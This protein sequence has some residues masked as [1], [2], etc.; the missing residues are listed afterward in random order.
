M[1]NL[2]MWAVALI[3]ALQVEFRHW[4]VGPD[5]T[6]ERVRDRVMLVLG[7]CER[8]GVTRQMCRQ[9][10]GEC[11]VESGLQARR[12]HASLC[13]CQPYDSGDEVQAQCAVRAAA[14]S[15]ALCETADEASTRYVDG[16]CRVPPGTNPRWVALVTQHVDQTRRVRAALVRAV[17]EDEVRCAR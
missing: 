9:A 10:L 8:Q 16:H 15:L 13:G 2:W 12:E 6:Y 4:P 1:I 5:E 7:E 14:Q 11:Y 17:V 3:A